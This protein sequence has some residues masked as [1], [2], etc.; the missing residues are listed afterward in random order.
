M[1]AFNVPPFTGKEKEYMADA[2]V[3]HKICGDGQFT[4]SSA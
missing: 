4:K 1:I 2:I 3:R